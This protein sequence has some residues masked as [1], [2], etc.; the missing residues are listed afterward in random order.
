MP[1]D[2]AKGGNGVYISHAELRPK[3]KNDPMWP[4]LENKYQ[5]SW[6][7][8]TG[9]WENGLPTFVYHRFWSQVDMA[10]AYAEYDRLIGN[11]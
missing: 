8:N 2:P 1:S 3:I 11:A 9:K 6:N 4:Y 7:P 10:T 5:T